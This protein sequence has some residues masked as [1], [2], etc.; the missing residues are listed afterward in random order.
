VVGAAAVAVAKVAAAT[1]AVR[2]FVIRVSL[3]FVSWRMRSIVPGVFEFANAVVD[4]PI[5]Q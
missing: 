4:G 1:R 3:S 2:V 5:H